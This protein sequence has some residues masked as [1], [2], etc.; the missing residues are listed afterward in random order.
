MTIGV[1]TAR[2]RKRIVTVLGDKAA[3]MGSGI[4]LV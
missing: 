4:S 1:E 2:M 3:R